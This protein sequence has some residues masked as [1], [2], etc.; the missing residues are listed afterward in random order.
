M[1]ITQQSIS[2]VIFNVCAVCAPTGLLNLVGDSM[3]CEFLY[4]A[5]G[6]GIVTPDNNQQTVAVC[7]GDRLHNVY[8]Y[9]RHQEGRV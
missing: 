1:L 4:R 9:S 2:Y 7:G 6:Q 3:R 5:N 8:L